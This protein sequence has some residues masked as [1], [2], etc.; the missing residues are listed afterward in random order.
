MV[1]HLVH[2]LDMLS[3]IQVAYILQ[4]PK[5][6]QRSLSLD[7]AAGVVAVVLRSASLLM[8]LVVLLRVSL[9]AAKALDRFTVLV[10]CKTRF[11]K[12]ILF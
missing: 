7:G 4:Q 8:R 1:N 10:N 6:Q 5:S 2:L 12:C 11:A 9:Q 3:I